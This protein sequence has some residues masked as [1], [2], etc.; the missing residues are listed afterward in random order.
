MRVGVGELFAVA[1]KVAVDQL[2]RECLLAHDRR[3]Y[4]LTNSKLRRA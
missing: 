2:V 1:V 3:G 4:P